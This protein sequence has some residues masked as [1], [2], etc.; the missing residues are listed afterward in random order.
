[1]DIPKGVQMMLE[2]MIMKLMTSP[3]VLARADGIAATILA[4]VQAVD[5]RIAR[6]EKL[7]YLIYAATPDHSIECDCPK[8]VS[9][10][11][12]EFDTLEYIGV[13]LEVLENGRGGTE[14]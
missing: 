4:K 1:M 5:D 10:R 8:C 12:L 6:I 13:P 7:S 9:V 11:K 3:E 2:N 14:H